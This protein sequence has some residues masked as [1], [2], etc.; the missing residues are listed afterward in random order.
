[1]ST[2]ERLTYFC[3]QEY[4][5]KSHLSFLIQKDPS[6]IIYDTT[7]KIEVERKYPA[8]KIVKPYKIIKITK[9]IVFL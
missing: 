2:V 3:S 9:P 6:K 8:L 7:K 4:I 5:S 1:M